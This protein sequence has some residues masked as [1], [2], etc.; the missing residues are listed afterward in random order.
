MVRL[1][2]LAA[3]L[4]KRGPQPDTPTAE[5]WPAWLPHY[6]AAAGAEYGWDLDERF[7]RD[8][9]ES[10]RCTVLLDGMDE[11][12][13]RRT[14]GKARPSDR[15]RHPRLSRLPAGRDQ[16][17]GRL[18]RATRC[19][20]AS[21]RPGSSRCRTRR[22]RLSWPA[23]AAPSTGTAGRGPTSTAPNCWQPCGPGR[24]SAAWPATRSCSPPW[25]SS[26]GT[27]AA[28]RNSGPICTSRSSPGCRGR[29]ISGRAGRRGTYRHAAAGTGAGYAGRH[30]RAARR[31]CPDAG[32]PRR[33]AA[34]FGGGPADKDA[35][36]HAE[37]FLDDEE[38]DSGIVV[39]RGTEWPSG[40]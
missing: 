3:H 20:P 9:L 18:P 23:G 27:N 5:D 34:E 28:C 25:P 36:A 29:A 33:L 40:T 32:P 21:P 14:A 35:V 13:D 1:S 24:R 6:L 17:S 19:C 37:R 15:E 26:T 31:R 38:I 4:A 39:G 12:P 2:E 7:F 16:S 30:R 10:G 22:S 8:Q 11:A